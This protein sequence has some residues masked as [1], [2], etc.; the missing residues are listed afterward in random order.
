MVKTEIFDQPVQARF[1][2]DLPVM[3]PKDIADAVIYILGTPKN[4][5]IHD[6]IMKPMGEMF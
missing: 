1:P 6:I 4:V 5:Q 2:V 3:E